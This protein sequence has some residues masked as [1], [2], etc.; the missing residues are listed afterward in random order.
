MDYVKV[1][2]NTLIK[3]FEWYGYD[4]Y[5]DGDKEEYHAVT[6]DEYIKLPCSPCD[7]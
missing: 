1:T 5:C 7:R 2:I 4:Y 6:D 3:C